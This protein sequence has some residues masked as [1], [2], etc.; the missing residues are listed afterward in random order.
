MAKLT[1]EE[2]IFYKTLFTLVSDNT[3]NEA[4]TKY[5]KLQYDKAVKNNRI[6]KDIYEFGY[7]NG[8]ADAWQH[9]INIK[10]KLTEIMKSAG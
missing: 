8:E 9:L 1:G 4:F 5:A 7:N 6:K 2:F 10:S 3:V